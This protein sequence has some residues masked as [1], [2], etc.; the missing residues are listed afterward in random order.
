MT[1]TGARAICSEVGRQGKKHQC[2]PMHWSYIH[3]LVSACVCSHCRHLRDSCFLLVSCTG[4]VG[5]AMLAD[6]VRSKDEDR[7]KRQVQAGRSWLLQSMVR[8]A[9]LS[10]TCGQGV[11]YS[12]F[13]A[14]VLQLSAIQSS[15]ARCICVSSFVMACPQLRVASTHSLSP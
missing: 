12:R 10:V 15:M 2:L 6:T 8:R 4:L 11:W 7:D 14:C 3:Q 13:H 9:A 5:S 1:G